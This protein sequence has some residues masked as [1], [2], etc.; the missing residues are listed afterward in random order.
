M[1]ALLGLLEK[2][3]VKRRPD[4]IAKKSETRLD[5]LVGSRQIATRRHR[6]RRRAPP[7]RGAPRLAP[8]GI[9]P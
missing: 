6:T 4:A 7:A 9:V 8:A 2:G 1:D 5:P 3:L